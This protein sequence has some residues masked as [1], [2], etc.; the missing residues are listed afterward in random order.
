MTPQQIS[1]VLSDIAKQAATI[2]RLVNMLVDADDARDKEALIASIET[3]AA[4]VGL[5]ADMALQRFARAFVVRGDAEQWT[6]PPVYFQSTESA[7]N[8]KG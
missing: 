6:M 4:R 8:V 7:L 5:V 3:A 2:D 1:C